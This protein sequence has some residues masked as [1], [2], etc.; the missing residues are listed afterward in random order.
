MDA[1]LPPQLAT[2]LRTKGHH[3]VALREVGLRDADDPEIWTYA[4]TEAAVIVTKDEDFAA[5][6][7]RLPSG[8]QV[9]WVRT[10]NILTRPLLMRFEAAWPSVEPL[11][12][13]GHR[14]IELR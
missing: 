8:P 9:L 14:L 4:E 12:A 7:G 5:M 1:Q 6:A 11:L 2:W 13:N 10:G 3:A